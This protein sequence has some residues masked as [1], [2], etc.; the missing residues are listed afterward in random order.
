[1]WPSAG[2]MFTWVQT[3]LLSVVAALETSRMGQ[4]YCLSR[5]AV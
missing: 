2:G 3:C 5:E 4:L 1:M